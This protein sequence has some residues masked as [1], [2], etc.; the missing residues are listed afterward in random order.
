[1]RV[2]GGPPV[3]EAALAPCPPSRDQGLIVSSILARIDSALSTCCARFPPPAPF[4]VFLPCAAFGFEF[5]RSSAVTPKSV[6]GAQG[7][8]KLFSSSNPDCFS[9]SDNRLFE[10]FLSVPPPPFPPLRRIIKK[11]GGGL[12]FRAACSPGFLGLR[13][14]FQKPLCFV[15]AGFILSLA[16]S[17]WGMS[18]GKGERTAFFSSAI[19]ALNRRRP[20]FACCWF[21][22]ALPCVFS[23][24]ALT[25]FS[26][27]A[28]FLSALACAISIFRLVASRLS[29][30]FQAR[31][32]M[33]PCR[34]RDL[35]QRTCAQARQA[36]RL[37]GCAFFFQAAAHLTAQPVFFVP[38]G[39]QPFK[40][41]FGRRAV[42]QFRGAGVAGRAA[43][44]AGPAIHKAACQ[45]SCLG[46][47]GKC[48]S[49]LSN[50]SLISMY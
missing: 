16:C 7:V 34:G 50:F 44:R 14:R 47:E 30:V 5:V 20:A 38:L 39:F 22:E 10:C 46:R 33:R 4:Y 13:I 49:A 17:R 45:Y 24:C 36:G 27:V 21:S 15:Q 48:A 18:S 37:S 3:R 41:G 42:R 8:F 28:F 6:R 9:L 25:S 40:L 31:C 35:P 12:S 29:F 11:S 19:A 32:L 26:A 23:S 2:L 1:M 43:D